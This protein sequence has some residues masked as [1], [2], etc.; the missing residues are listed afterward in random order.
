MLGGQQ[1]IQFLIAG[2]RHGLVLLLD[3]DAAGG[4]GEL[5]IAEAIDIDFLVDE[6]VGDVHQVAAL[7]DPL[8]PVLH[9][10]LVLSFPLSTWMAISFC[11]R[12][13]TPMM[14][15]SIIKLCVAM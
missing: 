14:F 10:I 2:C 3:V 13:K 5:L 1:H 9:L 8:V 12:A 11:C 15:L 7:I 4:A 6:R